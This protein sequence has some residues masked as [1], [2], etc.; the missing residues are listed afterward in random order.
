MKNYFLKPFTYFQE[1]QLLLFGLSLGLISCIIQ[2]TTTT[3]VIALLKA[4]ITEENPPFVQNIADFIITTI[5]MVL[6]L[7][8]FGKM[9]N[10]KTRFIDIL[11]T[12][13]IARIPLYLFI[14]GDIN[15]FITKKTKVILDSISN[16]D[17]MANQFIDIILLTVFGFL[18]LLSLI[19]FGYYIYQG[20]KTATHLKKTSHIIIFVILILFIDFLTR[21]LTNLY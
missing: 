9:I 2:L 21:L 12:V 4:I 3:R 7:F 8:I 5:T 18:V 20:F 15:S 13:L 11:N 1:K 6:A 19:I 10:A 14:I 17:E 16:P